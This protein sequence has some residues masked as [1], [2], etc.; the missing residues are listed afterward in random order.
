MSKNTIRKYLADSTF[1]AGFST[2]HLDYLAD[3]AKERTVA[4]GEVLFKLGEVA[5][6]FYFVKSGSIAVEIPA[7]Y[8]PALRVATITDDMILGWSWMIDPYDWDFQAKAYEDSTLIEFD[9]KA[10]LAHCGED[11]GFGYE[12]YRR[13]A[14]LMSERLLAA[15][16][17]MMEQWNPSGFA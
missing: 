1:L 16:Q 17:T 8:G 13:F 10:I 12:V 6:S 11:A 7:I 5:N 15:R 2:E 9:G 14:H 3:H 4:A